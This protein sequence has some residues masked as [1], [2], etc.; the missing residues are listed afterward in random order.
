MVMMSC[1]I[2][3]VI[4][5]SLGGRNHL[6]AAEFIRRR[7]VYLPPSL[8]PSTNAKLSNP[9]PAAP[10]TVAAALA[11]N[12]SITSDK[13]WEEV[14]RDLLMGQKLQGV[15]T[16]AEV[17]ACLQYYRERAAMDPRIVVPPFPLFERIHAIS[18]LK[19]DPLTLC[20]WEG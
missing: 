5:S 8:T 9:T 1:G 14:E 3:D 13:L 12:P 4:A 7:N 2:A 10:A 11:A 17:I 15:S 19:A 6:C 18:T 20:D 16:C